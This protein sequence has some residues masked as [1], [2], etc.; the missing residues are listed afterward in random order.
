MKTFDFYSYN[1]LTC[2]FVGV[3]FFTYQFSSVVFF[4]IKYV[5]EKFQVKHVCVREIICNNVQ[6]L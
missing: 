3:V 1:L 5:L 6:V 4:N 2:L